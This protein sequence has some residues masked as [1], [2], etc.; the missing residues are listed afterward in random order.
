MDRITLDYSIENAVNIGYIK[1]LKTVTYKEIKHT[2]YP[3]LCEYTEYVP[4]TH[5]QEVT[6]EMGNYTITVNDWQLSPITNQVNT[7][8]LSNGSFSLIPQN[9]TTSIFSV[10]E[11]Q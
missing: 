1:E 11:E 5:A 4:V 3:T 8:S 9:T 10:E 6:S 2:A 7:F